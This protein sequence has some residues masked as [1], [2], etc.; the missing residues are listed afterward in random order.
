MIFRS[1]KSLELTVFD[2]NIIKI[3]SLR[4]ILL[5]FLHPVYGRDK[6]AGIH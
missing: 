2:H 1:S 5:S 4:V 3:H 6:K